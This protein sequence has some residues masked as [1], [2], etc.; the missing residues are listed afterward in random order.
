MIPLWSQGVIATASGVHAAALEAVKKAILEANPG[1]EAPED[2]IV[3]EAV[4]DEIKEVREADGE[5]VE[6]GE[7]G[8]VIAEE[9]KAPTS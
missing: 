9:V 4:A 8:E 2:V 3:K 1:M 7:E 5:A 6:R